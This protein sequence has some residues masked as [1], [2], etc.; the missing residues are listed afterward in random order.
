MNKDLAEKI[1]KIIKRD[2]K[3][4]NQFASAGYRDFFRDRHEKK[5]IT[6]YGAFLI[7]DKFSEA[8]YWLNLQNAG[9]GS[10]VYHLCVRGDNGKPPLAILKEI[11]QDQ[12]ELKWQYKPRK[13]IDQENNLK[14]KALFEQLFGSANA[15]IQL[16]IKGTTLDDFLAKIFFLAKCVERAGNLDKS[17]VISNDTNK[18]YL[19][20]EDEQAELEKF[21]KGKDKNS[22]LEDLENLNRSDSSDETVSVNSKHYKRDNK[23]IALIKTLRGF[24]CQICET[25]IIKKD[26]SPYIEAAHITPKCEKGRETL[27][28]IILLC[29]NHHKEFDLG[30]LEINFRD[31]YEIEFILNTKEYNLKLSF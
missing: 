6:S 4:S 22:L 23:A 1:A 25:S 17:P 26:K 14:R 29:P 2:M 18:L 9:L 20:D 27:D 10:D 30:E 15:I 28:N 13:H 24:K 16:P 12:L 19:N 8:S 21:Y 7:K 5:G 3:E 11:S 31:E